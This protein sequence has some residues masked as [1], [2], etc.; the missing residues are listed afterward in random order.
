MDKVNP[1]QS[2]RYWPIWELTLSRMRVFYRE[3][4]AVFWVYGFPLVMAMSLGTAFR[5]NPKEQISV[6]VV[7]S[8]D[9]SA[10]ESTATKLAA[11]SRFQ[12]TR[13]SAEDWKKRLQAG[14]TDLV[15]EFASPG[16]ANYQLWDEPHRTESRLARYAVEAALS[17]DGTSAARPE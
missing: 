17:S 13:N 15:I 6:D 5:E 12:V 4:A 10:L 1:S 8:P 16:D 11:D 2:H 7:G 9:S 14:K 3:P